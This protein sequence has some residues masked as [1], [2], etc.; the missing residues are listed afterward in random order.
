MGIGMIT[1]RPFEEADITA[2]AALESACRPR[3]WSERVFADELAEANR[4]YLLAEEEGQVAGYAGA[5]LVGEEAHITN[6]L[7]APEFRRRGVAKRLMSRLIQ[8][9]VA[10]GARHLTLEV[11]SKNHAARRLYA[12]LGLAPVGVRPGYYGD[13]D[14][15]ILWAHDIDRP[16][17]FEGLA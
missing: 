14:A 7:V 11:G 15:L 12:T 1:V 5:M 2:V 10:E 13:D 6:L 17:F 9:A 4:I 16:G 8:A 3:P